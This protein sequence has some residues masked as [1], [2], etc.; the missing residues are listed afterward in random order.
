MDKGTLA[1]PKKPEIDLPTNFDHAFYMM[2]VDAGWYDKPTAKKY[3]E[4]S[5]SHNR[6]IWKDRHVK[7]IKGYLLGIE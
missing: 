3:F 4:T 2:I 1:E 5:V 7:S 6:Y